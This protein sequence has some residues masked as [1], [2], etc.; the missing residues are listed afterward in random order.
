MIYTLRVSFDIDLSPTYAGLNS[1]ELD[2]LRQALFGA[3]AP[4]LPFMISEETD[5]P[6]AL[7]ATQLQQAGNGWGRGAELTM[8]QSYHYNPITHRWVCER[9]RYLTKNGADFVKEVET[10]KGVVRA[11]YRVGFDHQSDSA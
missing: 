6:E 7:L 8:R 2:G 3:V 11:T 1:Q 9:D 4:L 5:D 10:S